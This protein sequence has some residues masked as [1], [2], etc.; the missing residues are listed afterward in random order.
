LERTGPGILFGRKYLQGLRRD[1]FPHKEIAICSYCNGEN[2]EEILLSRQGTIQSLTEVFQ[3]PAGGYYK[4]TVPFHYALVELDDGVII[5]THLTNVR[6]ETR[7]ETG[8]SWLSTLC[9][10]MEK[11]RCWLI[12]LAPIGKGE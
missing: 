4:G 2:L 8:W 7:L 3:K 9:M 6:P 12:N 5:Q 11:K 1:L 10:L